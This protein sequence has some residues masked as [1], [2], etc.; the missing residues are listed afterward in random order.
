M[1]SVFEHPLQRQKL[2]KKHDVSFDR[3][4]AAR[5]RTRRGHARRAACFQVSDDV[6]RVTGTCSALATPPSFGE[7]KYNQSP[8]ERHLH[9]TTPTN[10]STQVLTMSLNETT[11]GTQS[12]PVRETTPMGASSIKGGNAGGVSDLDQRRGKPLHASQSPTSPQLARGRI[13]CDRE[14]RAARRRA[15]R[16]GA[17]GAGPAKNRM[18]DERDGLGADEG[19]ERRAD[20]GCR[21]ARELRVSRRPVFPHRTQPSLAYSN[22]PTRVL[23]PPQSVRIS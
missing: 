1:L 3:S 10:Q 19:D 21:R 2:K 7:Y 18:G 11:S 15:R 17:C 6:T 12:P 20:Q 22:P 4:T 14:R 5:A 16:T 9:L 13:L 8:I 23:R